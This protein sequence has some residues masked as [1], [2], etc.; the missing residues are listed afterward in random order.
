M[1]MRETIVS[2]PLIVVTQLNDV[3]VDEI[4]RAARQV[5]NIT[6]QVSFFSSSHL[7][8]KI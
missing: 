1:R 5:L 3:D 4:K 7:R 2:L 8:T 6:Q